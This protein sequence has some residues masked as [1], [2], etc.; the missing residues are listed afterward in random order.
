MDPVRPQVVTYWVVVHQHRFVPNAQSWT[1]S[2]ASENQHMC[3][4]CWAGFVACSQSFKIFFNDLG[5]RRAEFGSD[6]LYSTVTKIWSRKNKMSLTE[7]G[8]KWGLGLLRSRTFRAAIG[9]S[10]PRA[11]LGPAPP[12]GCDGTF[13]PAVTEFDA[14]KRGFTFQMKTHQRVLISYKWPP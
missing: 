9:T 3:P 2:L 14:T 4:Y 10:Q 12:P 6:S 5:A 1:C 11:A 8:V 13:I 7:L